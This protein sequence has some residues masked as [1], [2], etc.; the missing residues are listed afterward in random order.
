MQQCKCLYDVRLKGD[1]GRWKNKGN[2]KQAD[3][4]AALLQ[5]QQYKNKKYIA[6]NKLIKMD[7][8][9][10]ESSCRWTHLLW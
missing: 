1:S 8:N 7:E 9:I 5:P 3:K 2:A 4:G 6:L 10:M